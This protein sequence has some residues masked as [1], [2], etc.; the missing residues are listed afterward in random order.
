MF[1]LTFVN[2]HK[3]TFNEISGIAISEASKERLF[4]KQLASYPCPRCVADVKV[5]EVISELELKVYKQ[6]SHRPHKCG[7]DGTLN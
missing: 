6:F 5:K 2:M 7:I 1:C 3:A 4:I